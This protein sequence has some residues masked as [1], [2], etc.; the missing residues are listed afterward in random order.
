MSGPEAL[1][2]ALR[3]LPPAELA[4]ALLD[5]AGLPDDLKPLVPGLPPE[6]VQIAT[7][8]RSGAVNLREAADFACAV[9]GVYAELC[10]GDPDPRVLDF[11][12]GWGRVTRCFLAAT[13]PGRILGVD[14]RESAVAM[15]RKLA[16]E[17]RTGLRF[18]T[19]DLLPP[20]ASA[21]QGALDL[22]T[23]YSVFSHLSEATALAW[24]H[25]FARL[26]RPGGLACLTIRAPWYLDVLQK[27][28]DDK[29]WKREGL[30]AEIARAK[31]DF[32]AG[33]FAFIP[34]GGGENLHGAVFGEAV[35]P[36]GYVAE[37]WCGDFE[38]VRQVEI[39]GYSQVADQPFV[40]L[41][42]R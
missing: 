26:L 2:R 25:E 8:A 12:C 21:G 9:R 42:R 29:I 33:R 34:L 4:A 13:R 23:A 10:P 14:P 17:A 5:G 38:L 20:L 32:A 16:P 11:G 3:A 7:T 1:C 19:S 40:V 30:A 39:A 28:C 22:I 18:E 15:C 41:R 6:D 27:L 37:R 24:I 35:L 31:A 36:P